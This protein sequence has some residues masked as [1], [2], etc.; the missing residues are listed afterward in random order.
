MLP[1]RDCD[2]WREPLA[3]TD[4]DS[5]P[6]REEDGSNDA[7]AAIDGDSEVDRVADAG[8]DA[9]GNS[10]R[11]TVVLREKLAV[12]DVDAVS[13]RDTDGEAVTLR[14]IEV[15]AVADATIL[16]EPLVEIETVRDADTL[17]EFDG[18]ETLAEAESV[19]ERERDCDA[20]GERL[21]LTVE[22]AA[23]HGLMLMLGI[24]D[25]VR[26]ALGSH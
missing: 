22:L 21:K 15:D 16:L 24:L 26:L 19:A 25:G 9:V 14:E 1:V 5:E 8:K 12:C 4:G 11:V 10:D 20:E 2:L 7:D 3:V 17:R 18:T 23:R 13:K 6:L